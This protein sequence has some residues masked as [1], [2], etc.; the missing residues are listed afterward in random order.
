[1]SIPR[2]MLPPEFWVV[3]LGNTRI[4][5]GRFCDG[6]LLEVHA[7]IRER[8]GEALE[9][10]L[11]QPSSGYALLATGLGESKWIAQLSS[12]A[13]VWQPTAGAA[14]LLKVAYETPQT[15][16]IDR[17]AA[18][19]G[20]A[21]IYPASPLLVIDAGT[22]ITYERVDAS[23]TYL[24]GNISP[25]LRLRLR[26]MHE[27]TGKLPLVPIRADVAEWGSNTRQALQLGALRGAA[28]EVAGAIS[29]FRQNDPK[30]YVLLCGGDVP[31]LRPLLP[32]GLDYRPHLVFEGMA[33][34]YAHAHA[35]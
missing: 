6:S 5:L 10:L 16:G 11:T 3:D 22:C 29:A 28:L 26:A 34:L 21:A 32:S 31:F 12:I 2:F 4:K 18:A 23:G 1:M 33:Q 8:A 19:A 15:L 25:G 9:W 27:F 24:G 20:A 35:Q 7:Y 14:G 13:K 30:G 17:L